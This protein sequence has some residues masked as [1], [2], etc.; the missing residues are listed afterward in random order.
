ME[1]AANEE[2][3]IHSIQLSTLPTLVLAEVTT[4]CLKRRSVLSQVLV[5]SSLSLHVIVESCFSIEFLV[6]HVFGPCHFLILRH[7]SHGRQKPKAEWDTLW[8]HHRDT[9]DARSTNVYSQHTTAAA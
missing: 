5:S 9:P 1:F 8:T 7:P 4:A 2:R 3:R 6:S